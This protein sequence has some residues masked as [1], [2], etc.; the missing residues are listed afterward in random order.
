MTARATAR[1]AQQNEA[2]KAQEEEEEEEEEAE[3]EE[4]EEDDDDEEEE[5]TQMTEEE[6]Q[7]IDAEAE[8]DDEDVTVAFLAEDRSDWAK[9]WAIPPVASSIPARGLSRRSAGLS[10][11]SPLGVEES[12]ESSREFVLHHATMNG[13]LCEGR[14]GGRSFLKWGSIEW[15]VAARENDL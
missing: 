13:C 12:E 11:R 3:E 9:S 8:D 10:Q 4:E 7:L 1:S 5:E 6:E 2:A 15:D 14:L